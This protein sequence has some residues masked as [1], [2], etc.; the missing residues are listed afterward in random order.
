[1]PG[2]QADTTNN[3]RFGLLVLAILSILSF[4]KIFLI[5]DLI[6]DD[7]C[8]LQSIYLTSTLQEFLDT[9]WTQLHR[10][11]VGTFQY[12]FLG[13][14][15]HTD[16]FFIVWHALSLLTQFVSAVFLYLLIRELFKDKLLALFTAIGFLVFHLDQSLP[17]ASVMNYRIGLALSIISLYLTIKACSERTRWGLLAL[18][19]LCA[20]IAHSVFIE[21]AIA[22]EP[23]RLAII[24]YWF[25]TQHERGTGL[26]RKTLVRW[27]PFLALGLPL[28]IYKLTNKPYGI[29]QGTYTVDPWFFL[30]WKQNLREISDLLFFDWLSFWKLSRYADTW[31]FAILPVAILFFGYFLWRLKTA[32]AAAATGARPVL[33]ASSGWK[34]MLL[35]RTSGVFALGFLFLLPPLL[36]VKFAGMG[37]YLKGTQN[38]AHAI[39]SQI[40]FAIILGNMMA[41]A[42]SRIVRKHPAH[43]MQYFLLGS[44]LGLGVYYNNIGLDLYQ[45]SW[46]RQTLFWKTF[47][48]R[49]PALPEKADFLFDVADGAPLSD[50][51]VHCDFEVNLNLLYA[52]TA[53]PTQFRKYR[54]ISLEDY[55]GT[56]VKRGVARLDDTPIERLTLW[57]REVLDP[58]QI[59]VVV[60]RY[61]QIL[62]GQEVKQHIRD[63]RKIPYSNWLDHELPPPQPPGG[64]PLRHRLR[65]F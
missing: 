31:S 32:P 26:V 22:L 51:R 27:S 15:R 8:W 19:G 35:S 57:G 59:V 42:F 38:N 39:F 37:L 41:L 21:P 30:D 4:W 7:N 1:M 54:V 10:F 46:R 55:H 12:F 62:V 40:G 61:G 2:T 3:T 6:W 44:V 36:M 25:Y 23:G 50:L 9:G 60:Y 49:F 48:A 16:Y 20:L 11:P 18:A 13:L 47:T 65:G 56:A 34:P 64:Y 58:N 45:D 29:Y 24:G 17:Y 33:Q 53:D 5:N 28:I 52:R 63:Y 43:K 14:H